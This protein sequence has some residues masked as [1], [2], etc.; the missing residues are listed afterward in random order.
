MSFSLKQTTKEKPPRISFEPIKNKVMGKRYEVSL[1]FCGAALSRSLNRQ[2]RLKDK[3][4]NV[5]SFPLSET[6][7]EVFICLSK[8]RVECKKFGMSLEKFVAYLF[9]HALLHLKGMAHGRKME[10]LE[11]TILNG[12]TNHRWY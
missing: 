11:S 12:A 8:A 5:L 6:S 1:V 9:I 7:G 2:Y 3:V 4:A 10:Q